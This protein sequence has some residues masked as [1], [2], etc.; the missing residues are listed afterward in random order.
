MKK[1]RTVHAKKLRNNLTETE[2]YLWYEL[3]CKKLSVKFRRQTIIGE[4]IV[5]FVCFMKR[6]V[7]EIDGGQH[8]KC[9]SD[10]IRDRWLKAQGFEVL[11][12]WNHEVLSNREGVI[13]KIIERLNIPL[14]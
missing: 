5:D 14:P 6:L 10:K 9:E 4:Y 1:E 13:T 3:K 7:V 2:K 11:R 12:F 8:A